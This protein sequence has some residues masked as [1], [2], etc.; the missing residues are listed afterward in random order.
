MTLLI[1][2]NPIVKRELLAVL[3]TRRAAVIQ[4]LLC[5][6]LTALVLLRWPEN[7]SVDLTGTQARNVLAV[8]GYGLMGAMMLLAPVFPATSIVRERQQGTLS[9]L[10]NSPMSRVEIFA[11]KLVGV[12]GFILLLMTLSLPAAAA[13][14][15]MGGV[16]I[17]QMAMLYLT[18]TLLALQ[19]GT[20]GLWVS[21]FAQR[22][23][24]ALRMAYG[25]VLLLGVASIGP[26]QFLHGATW[27]P[28][29]GSVA[30]DW[31][32]CLS[33]IPAVME[34]LGQ[35]GADEGGVQSAGNVPARF[36][37]LAAG[38]TVVLAVWTTRRLNQKLF[39]VDRPAGRI[40]DDRS[41]KV[42]LYRRVM[43]MWFFD[44]QRRSGLIGPLTNPVMV[45]EFRTRKFGRAHWLARLFG[46]CLVLSLALMLATT[47][48]TLDWGPATLGGIVVSLSGALIVLVTPSLASGIIAGERESGG[49]TLLKMTPMS[50][51]SIVTGKLLSV[52]WTLALVL[53]ATL[54]GYLVLMKIDVDGKLTPKIRDVSIT[55]ALT[56]ALA[57]LMSAAVSALCRKTTT[58][59]A[60]AYCLLVGVCGGPLLFWMGLD[61]PFPR[62]RV[63]E[64][65][66][67]SPVAAS[68]SLIGAPGFENFAL[69]PGAWYVAGGLSAASVVVLLFQTWR[70][71]RP[72]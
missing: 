12:L 26:F 13:C 58:A 10:L 16:S 48:G 24:S 67:I 35:G 55:L 69:L 64:V 29:A 33:P 36:V 40:T 71:T 49:W 4:A 15:A 51:M 54:P 59:T 39:D 37:M 25:G 30:V 65:L 41:A 44:P 32:R 31:M 46:G 27:M 17:G 70:L 42:R 9:L 52:A 19:Y 3:R 50:A 66:T 28:P 45:K 61:A 18:L 34:L 57:V 53:L 14:Y 23:D 20:L 38:C 22:A 8:F 11:G 62:H 63:E 2:G 68:L 56:A 43:Y 72:Q 5:V 60:G 7:A 1:F 47:R 6:A 21:S